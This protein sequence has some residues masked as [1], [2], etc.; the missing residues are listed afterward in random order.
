[1]LLL[2]ESSSLLRLVSGTP[3]RRYGVQMTGRIFK[4]EWIQWLL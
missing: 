1:V 3:F 2:E 4:T